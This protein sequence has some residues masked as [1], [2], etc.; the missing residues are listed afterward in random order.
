MTSQIEVTTLCELSTRRLD[1][2]GKVRLF[3]ARSGTELLMPMGVTLFRFGSSL[4]FALA[5]VFVAQLYGRPLVASDLAL[6]V[7]F[8]SLAAV[9]SAGTTGVLSLSLVSMVCVPLFPANGR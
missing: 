9:A 1:Q 3:E 2:D 5:A 7:G 4:Y 6:I 8:A